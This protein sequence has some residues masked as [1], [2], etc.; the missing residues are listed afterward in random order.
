MSREKNV[1]AIWS[2]GNKTFGVGGKSV[3]RH[4]EPVKPPRK[5]ASAGLVSRYGQLYRLL[6]RGSKSFDPDA[7]EFPGSCWCVSV[8]VSGPR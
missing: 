2:A 7:Q 3:A 4:V 6:E 1:E 8:G 5:I